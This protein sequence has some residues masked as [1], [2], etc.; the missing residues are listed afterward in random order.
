MQGHGLINGLLLVFLGTATKQNDQCLSFLGQVNAI[1]GAPINN[2]FA[3]SA[4]PFDVGRIPQFNSGLCHCNFCGGLWIQIV[5]P[6]LIWNASVFAVE[7][8]ILPNVKHNPAANDPEF[9][10][11]P[12]SL[13][14]KKWLGGLHSNYRWAA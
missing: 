2:A 4:K 9:F 10:K 6:C 12:C 14:R 7:S 13:T 5:E 3:N 8:P 11:T 1:A